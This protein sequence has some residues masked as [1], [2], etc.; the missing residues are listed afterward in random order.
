MALSKL[1]ANVELGNLTK[2]QH[3]RKYQMDVDDDYVKDKHTEQ[4]NKNS[5][6]GEKLAEKAFTDYLQAMDLEEFT[7]WDFDSMHL[8][9]LL[10]KFWFAVRQTEVDPVTG[11]G[12]RYKVQ[13]LKTLRYAL[14]RVIQERG[15]KHNILTGDDFIKSQIAFKDACKELKSLGY[16]FVTPTDEITPEGEHTLLIFYV[17]FK[18]KVTEIK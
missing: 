8:D 2:K 5:K 4:A 3:K 18:A 6:R 17:K 7:F 14:N 15:S 10:S 9:N 12:K 11:E 16:G 13:S 1:A